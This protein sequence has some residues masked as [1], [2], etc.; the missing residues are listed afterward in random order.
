MVNNKKGSDNKLPYEKPRLRTIN[1]L[2]DEV[3]AVK[4]K[5]SL[6]SPTGRNGQGCGIRNCSIQIGS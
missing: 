2:A 1:L 5:Q 6:G 4:C 3:L